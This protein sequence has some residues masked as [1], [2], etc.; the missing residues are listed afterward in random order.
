MSLS[1]MAS[2]N[3][4]MML[5]NELVSWDFFLSPAGHKEKHA[6]TVAF[7]SSYDDKDNQTKMKPTLWMADYIAKPVEK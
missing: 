6:A 5:L 7:G 1:K 4:H 2:S 3:K